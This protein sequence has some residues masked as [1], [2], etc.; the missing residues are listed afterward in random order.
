M[1]NCD[2]VARPRVA[3]GAVRHRSK[4]VVGGLGFGFIGKTKN[5]RKT[6]RRKAGS[7]GWIRQEGAFA[8]RQCNVINLSDDGVQI[9][10][11]ATEKIPSTFTLLLSR[12]ARSGRRARVKWRRGTQIG[13]QFI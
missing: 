2:Q 1:G 9:A 10:I 8:V 5:K 12:D 7:T 3:P 6:A 13:A 11:E 4:H